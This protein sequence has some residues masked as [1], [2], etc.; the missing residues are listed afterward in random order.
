M[1]SCLLLAIFMLH[2]ILA[3]FVDN[4]NLPYV[5]SLTAICL[6]IIQE[7]LVIL[8]TIKKKER[9]PNQIVPQF[10]QQALDI[11]HG[12][13]EDLDEPDQDDNDVE[14]QNFHQLQYSQNETN[15][16]ANNPDYELSS[17]YVGR[18]G[19]KVKVIAVK[20]ITES[21]S[22]SSNIT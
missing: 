3:Q 8:L 1:S 13:E 12:F 18:D 15:P 4:D 21:E 20:S 19:R 17:D 7:P 11:L 2:V 6:A 14:T 22:G 9:N 16:G 10:Q 5:S